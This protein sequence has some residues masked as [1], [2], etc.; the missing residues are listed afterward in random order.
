MKYEVTIGIPDYNVGKY[1][2]IT[3]VSAI[4]SLRIAIFIFCYTNYADW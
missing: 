1:S 3:I 2:R 4:S